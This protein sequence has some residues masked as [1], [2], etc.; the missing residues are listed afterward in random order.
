MFYDGD[1]NCRDDSAVFC[2]DGDE[3]DMLEYFRYNL[4]KWRVMNI[5]RGRE[6]ER[7]IPR[8]LVLRAMSRVGDRVLVIEKRTIWSRFEKQEGRR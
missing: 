8:T 1:K 4:I 6:R 5:D 2:V 7:E 3:E